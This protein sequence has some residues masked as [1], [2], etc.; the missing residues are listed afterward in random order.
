MMAPVQH[1]A[2]KIYQQRIDRAA[3]ELHADGMGA[4]R[5][6]RQQGCRLAA[7]TAALTLA[8]DQLALLQLL[9]DHAGGVVRQADIAGEIRLGRLT[10][11]TK[12]VEDHTFIEKANIDRVAALAI[13]RGTVRQG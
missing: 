5:V 10:Q 1:M 9:D 3:A 6:E 2:A 4:V 13:G 11:A 12:R 8:A 7:S